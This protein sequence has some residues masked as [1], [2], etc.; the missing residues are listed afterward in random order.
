MDKRFLSILV[1]IALI[2]GGFIFINQK[3]S[4]SSGTGNNSSKVT[5]TNHTF[6]DG[7][8]NV[9][10]IEY[11]DLQCPA[12]GQ[13][14]PIIKSIK[15]KYKSDITFQYRNFPLDT[16]HQNARAAHRAT[17]AASNQGKFWEMHNKLYETQNEWKG[18]TNVKTVFE[19]YASEMGLDITKFRTDYASEHTNDVINADVAEGKK[20]GAN[21]TP[22]FVLEGVKIE[23]NP[24]GVDEFGK[25]IDA[26]IAKKNPTTTNTDA[27][28]PQ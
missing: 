27:T 15:E 10:L 20:V 7:K 24:R 17:E 23:E 13:Y 22:T 14:Y 11:G 25:L 2:F 12:C 3:D 4:T 9:T 16:I 18:L 19:G 6:G 26:A 5:P 8:K 28:K 21:S 1:I